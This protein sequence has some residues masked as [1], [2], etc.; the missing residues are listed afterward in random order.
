MSPSAWLDALVVER[1]VLGCGIGAGGVEGQGSSP[2]D[3]E[4]G[5]RPD[6]VAQVCA[7]KIANADWTL[8]F[9]EGRGQT[10]AIGLQD[11]AVAALV[12]LYLVAAVLLG[13]S[14]LST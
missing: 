10:S 13:L 2:L 11:A 12:L 7:R 1:G 14:C 5:G 3:S 9:P 4:L 8:A 6:T